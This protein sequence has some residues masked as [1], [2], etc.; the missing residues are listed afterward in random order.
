MAASKLRVSSPVT[1]ITICSFVFITLNLWNQV[2]FWLLLI[3]HFSSEFKVVEIGRFIVITLHTIFLIEKY[4][5]QFYYFHSR[6][7]KVNIVIVRSTNM[8]KVINDFTCNSGLIRTNV[9][10]KETSSSSLQMQTHREF[11]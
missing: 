2:D 11:R 3:Y 7:I 4:Y 9:M 5:W 6:S 10:F 8:F 1:F